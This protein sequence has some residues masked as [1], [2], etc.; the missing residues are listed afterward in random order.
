M[1][2]DTPIR[3]LHFGGYTEV[4]FKGSVAQA[5]V[6]KNVDIP[7]NR[8][9][10]IGWTNLECAMKKGAKSLASTTAEAKRVVMLTDG[11]PNAGQTHPDALASVAKSYA[12]KGIFFDAIGIGSDARNTLLATIVG[13]TGHQGHVLGAQD[14]EAGLTTFLHEL[15]QTAFDTCASTGRMRVRV[16][17]RF[18]VLGAWRTHPHRYRLGGRKTFDGSTHFDIN[19]GAL[20]RND[21]RP[22][23]VIEL[24]A[25]TGIV[26]G[27]ITALR[28]EG[29]LQQE[30]TTHVFGAPDISSTQIRVAASSSE[31]YDPTLETLVKGYHLQEETDDRVARA[32]SKKERESIYAQAEQTAL[33]IDNPDLANS[34][35]EAS[36]R[37]RRGC[38]VESVRS[39]Q[40]VTSSKLSTQPKDLLEV[41]EKLDTELD[42]PLGLLS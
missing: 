19:T 2:P 22:A 41:C 25:P 32:R 26:D 35:R 37:L 8:I 7:Q 29:N 15:L 40:R 17:P 12:K 42:D 24:A 3:I 30:G 28:A 21:K 13:E 5:R 6:S 14:L 9:R 27:P 4:A 33:T 31:Q 38:H 36:T 23:Y 34:Y 10:P 1:H 18:K 11:R 20:G 39:T 16:D